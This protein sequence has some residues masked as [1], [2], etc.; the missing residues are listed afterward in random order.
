MKTKYIFVMGGVMSGVGK[1]IAVASIARI[2]QNKGYRVSAIKIDPYVNVDAGT[3]NPMEHGETFV[4]EDGL[5]TD[6]DLGHYERFLNQDILKSNYLT[7]G[8]VYQSVI[9]RERN[10]EYG[11]RC[12]EVVPDIPNEVLDRI[13]RASRLTMSEIMIIEIGGTVGEYQNMLFLEAARMARLNRPNDVLFVMLS[14]LPI[15]SKIG[16]M[17]TKPTQHAV[18]ILNSA[19][20]QPDFILA[21]SAMPLDQI[22][23]KKISVFCSMDEQDVISAP[24]VESIYDIPLNFEKDDLGKRILKKFK[25]RNKKSNKNKQENLKQWAKLA[26][27]LRLSKRTVKIGL[28]GKY[29]QTG[30][31]VLSDSYISV[32]EALKH[33]CAVNNCRPDFVWISTTEI[34]KKGTNLLKC[35]DGVIVPQGWGSRGHQEMIKAIQ[36][37]REKK[38]PFLGLCY[39]MQMSVIEFARNVAGLKKANSEEID[40]KTLYPVIHIMEDQKEYLNKKQYGGTIRL[41]AWPCQVKQGTKLRKIYQK[42]K[43]LERHRHRYEFNNDYRQLLEEKGLVISGVSP[44]N[45]LVEAIELKNHPFFIATQF[46]PEYKSRFLNPHPIFKQFIKVCLRKNRFK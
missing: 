30:K 1:G 23:K 18:R 12:V 46:H 14:F 10:L 36:Y 21:R 29:F 42:T 15:P 8:S 2:L 9:N 34:A 28:V 31:F 39:G 3:M 38:K 16:E 5:E 33:A 32:I 20:I 43:V 13:K 37:C 45:R 26:K 22:R 11:G 25:L 19:G 44:D 24:D 35:L 17:K 41:G 27:A 6:Q 7:T 4:T 40:S